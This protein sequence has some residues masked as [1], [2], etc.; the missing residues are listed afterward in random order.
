M[1]QCAHSWGITPN[2]FWDMTINEWFALHDMNKPNNHAGK[3]TDDVVNDI[4]DDMGLTDEEWWDKH[5][6]PGNQG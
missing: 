4:V 3:L 6:L 2:D 1:F 5:G